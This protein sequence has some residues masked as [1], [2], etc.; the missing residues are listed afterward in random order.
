VRAFSLVLSPR[1]RLRPDRAI[2]PFVPHQSRKISIAGYLW[3]YRQ[4]HNSP[5]NLYVMSTAS[6]KRKLADDV[7]KYYA[8]RAGKEPGVYLTWKE[9]QDQITG[10][11][12]AQFKSFTSRKDAEDFAAGK[13]V[14]SSASGRGEEEKFYGVAVG[15]NPGVYETWGEA[16]EQ[17]NGVKGPRYKK[18][19]T[20]KEAEEFV[21]SGGKGVK[22]KG[23]SAK[24]VKMSSSKGK[25]V[26]VYTDGSSRKNGQVGAVAGVG[27]YFGEG[28][29]RNVS[30]PLEGLQQTNQRAEL[31]AILRALQIVPK[32]QNLEII[33]D[34]NYSINCSTVWYKNW[35]KNGWTTSGK[36]PVLNKDLVVDIRKLIDQRDAAGSTTEMTWIKGHDNDPGNEAAD[37]LA[38][39]GAMAA[40]S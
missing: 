18:F 11:K 24:K 32:T 20:R 30:E 36:E 37:K 2:P 1:S 12:G 28:D 26:H 16:Q 38:V 35:Q 19:A 14:T 3:K 8:V 40:R 29:E 6:K 27:V 5:Q 17:I 33:T 4:L 15:H 39:A 9:C 25:T 22:E 10:F 23:P 7:T 21:K 34:S 31:T 13:N